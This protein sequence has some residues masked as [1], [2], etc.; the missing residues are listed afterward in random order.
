MKVKQGKY[1]VIEGTDGTGK[2]TQAEN[3]CHRLN[4]FGIATVAFHEP[5]GVEISHE[6]RNIIKNGKL[7]RSALT[8]LLLFSASRRENWLQ[9]GQAALKSGAWIL[10]SRNYISTMVY[11]GYGEGLDLDLIEQITELATD[12]HYMDPDHCII[13]DIDDEAERNHRIARRGQLDNLDTFESRDNSFQ[14]SVIEGYRS[15]AKTKSL[16]VISASQPIDDIT[17]QIWEIIRPAGKRK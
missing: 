12:K 14:A 9:K 8:N 15:I 3:I 5:D 16:P 1:V 4:K 7:E 11:Q 6:L 2:S 13:L 17:D 10:S